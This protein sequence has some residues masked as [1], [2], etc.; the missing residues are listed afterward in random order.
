MYVLY[1]SLQLQNFRKSQDFT[2]MYEYIFNIPCALN[3]L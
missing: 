1:S 3:T 2:A